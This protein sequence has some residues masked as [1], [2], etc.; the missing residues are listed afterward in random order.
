[1]Q[2]GAEATAS[3]EINL[4]GA[5]S[6]FAYPLLRQWFER[7]AAETGV[8][9]NYFSVG[10]GEG[11][12]LL[13]E[14]DVDFGATDRPLRT[15]ETG[16]A[17]CG[18][19]AIP[20]VAG[21][22]AAVYNLPG[23]G[24]PLRLDANVLS[25]IFLGRITQWDAR[26]LQALNPDRRLPALPIT[27]VFRARTSGTSEV[28]AAYLDGAAEWRAHQ[29]GRAERDWPVGV[30]LEGNE[31]VAIEVR[32]TPGAIGFAEASY[33]RQARL[34][35][36]AL[37]NRSGA[38]LTPDAAGQRVALTTAELLTA[39]SVDTVVGLVGAEAPFAYPIAGVTR[40]VADQVIGDA[41]RARQFITFVRWA[42]ANGAPEARELGYAP[43]PDAVARRQIERLE[44]IR[45]GTCAPGAAR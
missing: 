23:D 11:I 33:A 43:L 45:P 36:A 32:V 6:T 8:R 16:R 30:S 1:M 12:R 20:V 38:Y 10:S 17:R 25:G 2:A 28:F 42:L 35:M 26:A 22:V 14:E 41:V 27:V 15:R 21:A 19:V 7:Y 29:A 39:E 5:G 9:I 31:G 34:D 40:L 37:R 3:G 13:F 44:T 24:P 4:I 18:P